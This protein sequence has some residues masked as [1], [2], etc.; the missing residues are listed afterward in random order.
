[1]LSPENCKE[2]CNKIYEELCYYVYDIEDNRLKYQSFQNSM[3]LIDVMEKNEFKKMSN[4]KE[5]NE[6]LKKIPYEQITAELVFEALIDQVQIEVDKNS[7][8]KS[9]SSDHGLK[10]LT[11]L[12]ESQEDK[13]ILAMNK[14]F[15]FKFRDRIILKN[16][17]K[18]MQKYFNGSMT[19]IENY[20]LALYSKSRKLKLL[21][22]FKD[23][24]DLKQKQI[25][26]CS[27]QDAS[28]STLQSDIEHIEE[29]L[30]SNIFPTSISKNNFKTYCIEFLT[31]EG[32]INK[33][34]NSIENF[35][36]TQIFPNCFGNNLILIKFSNHEKSIFQTKFSKIF[37]PTP[38]CYRDFKK[39][40]FN[41]NIEETTDEKGKLKIENLTMENNNRVENFNFIN[42]KYFFL[43]QSLKKKKLDENQTINNENSRARRSTSKGKIIFKSFY[44]NVNKKL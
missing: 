5:Y 26:Y 35:Q 7:T 42:E 32:I 2:H 21:E 1:M 31:S 3:A 24:F 27:Q 30:A 40:I 17:D 20:K 43:N 39:F 11:L 14:H 44:P 23:F 22:F 4:F 6:N 15:I 9:I 36:C 12:C 16:E 28:T 13:N 33:I 37:I 29:F 8:R 41:E 34:G 18:I 19:N 38:L 25:T 10:S